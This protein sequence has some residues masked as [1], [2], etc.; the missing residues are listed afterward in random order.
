VISILKMAKLVLFYE[1]NKPWGQFSNFYP[2]PIDI[3]GTQYPTNEHFYQALKFLGPDQTIR[4]REYAELIRQQNTPNKAKILANQKL[5]GGYAWVKP[6]N[7]IIRAYPD[8][9]MRA[10]FEQVKDNLMRWGVFQKFLQ[11]PQL[12]QILDSTGLS[13]LAEHTSRDSY[14]G[15]GGDGSGKNMLGRILMETRSILRRERI[16][17]TEP[18]YEWILDQVLLIRTSNV[19]FGKQSSELAREFSSEFSPEMSNEI[20]VDALNNLG[21]NCMV[22]LSG[23]D[24]LVQTILGE[25]TTEPTYIY[26]NNIIFLQLTGTDLEQTADL[27]I[28]LIGQPAYAPVYSQ[29]TTGQTINRGRVCYIDGS[30]EQLMGFLPI[31]WQQLYHI[32]PEMAEQLT[33]EVLL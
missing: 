2:S 22:D 5:K 1:E 9:T 30:K 29:P 32:P 24:H 13:Y 14:W 12:F 27:L 7:E 26:Q 28:Q 33:R 18:G 23:G 4:S 10:D 8:V 19:L 3:E 15:D 25:R 31:V 11:N 20:S 21:V 16:P 6:L 17:S